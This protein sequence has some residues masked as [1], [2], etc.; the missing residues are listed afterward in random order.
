MN[1]SSTL[2][3]PWVQWQQALLDEAS[4]NIGR[5]KNLPGLWQRAQQ[6]RKGVSPAEIV[7]EEDRLKLRHYVGPAKP[8]H[9]TP[10]VFIYALVNR[11]YILDLK[12][13]RSVVANFVERGFDTY[14]VDWGIPT[15]ADRHLTLEDYINGYMVN[16]LD[17]LRERTGVEQVNVLGYCMGGTMS[18]M[19]T[20]LHP[21]CVRNLILLAAPIDFA[22]N[23]SLLNLWTRP[24]N[25]DVDRLVDAYGN[26]PPEFLQASFLMLRP[27]GNFLEKP[28]AFYEHMHEEKFIEDFLTTETWLQDNIP[29][30][31][32]VYRQF[33]KYLYQQN[34]LTQN[35]M[36]VG[37]RLVN[38]RSITCPV[39]N[40]MAGKDDLVPCSQ[41][42][43]FN[44]L[45]GSRDRKTL[46]L[47]GSGHIGLA[48]GGRAQK[49]IWPQACQWLA[50]RSA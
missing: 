48:I 21:K 26:C 3:N 27:V 42:T 24:E 18:A 10:L 15:T 5:M 41:S 31:G 8:R 2:A 40:I 1:E 25:F 32:E 23:D 37:K 4:A 47:E 16:V 9:K 11:P 39:L 17:Y 20:A 50:E 33:V 28:L 46:C 44:D 49:D 7:Y 29:V 13:G 43:P 34:L 30:P 38:L 45:V 36:P 6:V 19:F 22:A 14:L 35:R 12:K